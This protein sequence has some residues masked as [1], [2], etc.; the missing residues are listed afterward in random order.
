M[1]AELLNRGEDAAALETTMIAVRDIVQGS[2]SSEQEKRDLLDNIATRPVVV[3]NIAIQRW[4]ASDA[5]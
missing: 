4:I 2:N 3:E 5:A 1:K